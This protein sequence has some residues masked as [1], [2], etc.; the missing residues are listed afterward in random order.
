MHA[1]EPSALSDHALTTIMQRRP[2][3]MPL[4]H[5]TGL[6]S[7]QKIG[8]EIRMSSSSNGHRDG[9]PTPDARHREILAE[10]WAET[11]GL[12][13]AEKWWPIIKELGI[14]AE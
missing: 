10:A 1:Q 5:W 13:L 6:D 3:R 4:R 8:G 2:A 14:R 9:L 7:V 12:A 11:L